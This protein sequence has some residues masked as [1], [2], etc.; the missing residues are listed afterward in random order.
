MLMKN[1]WNIRFMVIYFSLFA[2]AEYSS[3]SVGINI[4]GG[5]SYSSSKL[6]NAMVYSAKGKP[7]DEVNHGYYLG[8]GSTFNNPD[9]AKN[10]YKNIDRVMAEQT[11]GDQFTGS[12]DYYFKL[13]GGF[14]YPLFD[15][16]IA[17]IGISGGQHAVARTYY[18]S[19]HIL[20]TNGNY[21]IIDKSETGYGING[22]L[23]YEFNPEYGVYILFDSWPGD[24]ALGG[25]ISLTNLFY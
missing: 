11:F 19:T 14:V 1:G 17:G 8:I 16:L 25:S 10:Y 5:L 2:M 20:G 13:W 18:D 23:E 4:F 24:I 21:I 9:S 22:F 3:D 7:H 6:I 15:K 12:Y